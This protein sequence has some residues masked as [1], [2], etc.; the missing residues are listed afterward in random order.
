VTN[1]NYT[2]VMLVVDRSDSMRSIRVAAEGG[3]NEF[4]NRQRH[5]AGKRTI[6]IAQFD[7]RYET[8]CE[9]T[10]PDDIA[11]FL[12]V[13]RG[14]TALLDAMGR[15]M[16]Q[17]GE[18]LAAL[19][20]DQRPATVIY[21]VMT[22]GHENDSTEYDWDQIKE[23]VS[24]QQNEYGWQILYLAANQ[25]AFVVGGRLGVPHG[26]TMTYSATDHGTRSMSDSLSSYVVAAASGES[27]SFTD[28][29]RKDAI[30]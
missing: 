27:V 18:E 25:D 3:I 6:R 2:A 16:T 5:T 17:F 29:Q 19:P 22:D 15:S 10:D 12:L 23:L 14:M 28:E 11:P 9:S 7:D 4:I 13:P 8:V 21:A 24:R 20:E 1:P 26:Q 30:Q